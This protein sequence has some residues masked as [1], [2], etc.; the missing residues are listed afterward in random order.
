MG[1]E[2]NDGPVELLDLDAELMDSDLELLG[3]LHCLQLSRHYYG[4]L[5]C[6]TFFSL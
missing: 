1:R 5:V 2:V 6:S 3:I 4:S